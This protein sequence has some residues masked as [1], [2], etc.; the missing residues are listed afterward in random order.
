MFSREYI[1]SLKTKNGGFTRE[2]LASLG[3]SWPPI[4]GWRRKIQ[5]PD[6]DPRRQNGGRTV[7]KDYVPND[8]TGL[9]WE[10]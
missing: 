3:V 1:D 9:P 2:T 6:V 8:E 4:K 10:I 7:G 5:L